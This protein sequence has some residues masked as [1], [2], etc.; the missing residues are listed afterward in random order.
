MNTNKYLRLISNM[1]I[2][3]HAALYFVRE[4]V[5][6]EPK[7]MVSSHPFRITNNPHLEKQVDMFGKKEKG[8]RF[9]LFSDEGEEF[10]KKN[11]K[12]FRNILGVDDSLSHGAV[13]ALATGCEEA[14]G[15]KVPKVRYED[16]K[17]MW[18]GGPLP[19]DI[20]NGEEVEPGHG[21]PFIPL[22]TVDLTPE[23]D[24]EWRDMLKK[25]V[26]G[27]RSKGRTAIKLSFV[28]DAT[29]EEIVSTRLR[30]KWR[31]PSE[32][33]KVI[34]GCIQML[35]SSKTPGGSELSAENELNKCMKAGLMVSLCDAI[36][37]LN[38]KKRGV[39][40]LESKP[41]V[42]EEVWFPYLGKYTILLPDPQTPE[43]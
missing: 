41:L 24:K 4:G 16:G 3:E 31:T 9:W 21:V 2:V 35:E 26:G 1:A 20:E 43:E 10:I 18:R 29:E 17:L 11:D 34:D 42:M 33:R 40:N 39:D 32:S 6:N 37:V 5:G 30:M 23:E 19:G 14:S 7:D 27:M 13:V 28:D 22:A 36:D 25:G 38:D 8:F 15:P 12:S